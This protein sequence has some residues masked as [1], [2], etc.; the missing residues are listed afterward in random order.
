MPKL[1]Q[2][3]KNKALIE[4]FYTHYLLH[5]TPRN[6]TNTVTTKHSHFENTFNDAISRY[7]K[8]T[9]R[10][11]FVAATFISA[12]ALVGL[13][14]LVAGAGALAGVLAPSVT[15]PFLNNVVASLSSIPGSI[16]SIVVAVMG[17][18][19]L[20]GMLTSVVTY[21]HAKKCA[22]KV[23]IPEMNKLKTRLIKERPCN[24]ASNKTK[25]ASSEVS[26][27]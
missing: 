8:V 20:T 26:N 13:A 9:S 22:Q 27:L 2:E 11:S 12:G 16:T 23:I 14:V 1:T 3:D 17:T 10:T 6:K 4:S 5:A 21:S 19:L 7:I 25:H 18:I 15:L 24:A